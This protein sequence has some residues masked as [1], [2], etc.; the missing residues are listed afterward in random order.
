M[1]LAIDVGGTK[2]LLAIFSPEGELLARQKIPTPKTYNGLIKDLKSALQLPEF[3]SYS[4]TACCCAIPGVVDRR[5]GVGLDF[6]NLPWHDVPILADLQK[7]LK[8]IRIFVDNDA[9]LAGVYE[10][11]RH[12][13]YKKVLYVTLS[14]GIG[15][16]IIVDGKI[17]EAFADSEI[18][19]MV[20]EHE[21]KI[22]KWEDFASGK[23]L[24]ER[25]G[26][27]AEHLSNPFSWK[28]YAKDVAKGLDASISLI[29]PDAIII[30]GSVGAHLEKFLAPLK[31][32]LIKYRNDMVQIPPIIKAD[33]AEE[34]VIYGCYEF[35][36]QNT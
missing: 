15:G 4:I 1:Y 5:S 6:G 34:A 12:P 23:A 31:D 18:G 33:K 22:Q 30:G 24:V 7:I 26:M 20:L 10:A 3:K 8:H 27:K 29:Q 13:K 16:G 28:S 21:G 9:N 11:S 35:I 36:R 14:T 19:H 17:D 2:T 25:F 32:E